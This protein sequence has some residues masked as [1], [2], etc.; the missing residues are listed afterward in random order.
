MC[1]WDFLSKGKYCVLSS[2]PTVLFLLCWEDDFYLLLGPGLQ[3]FLL[4]LDAKG[5]R[6][7]ESE[8]G[9]PVYKSEYKL[10]FVLNPK[11]DRDL[12]KI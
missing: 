12:Y 7:I 2:F 10:N 9:T 6:M 4:V 1:Y 3:C 8:V 11:N 5:L